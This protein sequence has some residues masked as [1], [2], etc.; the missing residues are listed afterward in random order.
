MDGCSLLVMIYMLALDGG[1]GELVYLGCDVVMMFEF[2]SPGFILVF[3]I[4]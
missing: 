2:S 1:I 4:L 3:V